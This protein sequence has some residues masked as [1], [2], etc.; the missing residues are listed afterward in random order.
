MEE[1]KELYL[2][3]ECMNLDHISHLV[4]FPLTEEEKKDGEKNKIYFRVKFI[5]YFDQIIPPIRYFYS[6]SDWREYFYYNCFK[7]VGIGLKNIFHRYFFREKG[8]IDFTNFQNKDLS[9]LDIFL[10]QLTDKIDT[11]I[12]HQ[13]IQRLLNERWSI[14][15]SIE[16]LFEDQELPYQLEWNPQFLQCQNIWRRIKNS[17][18]YIFGT[19]C[20]E[21]EFEITEKEASKLRGMIKWIQKTN[22]KNNKE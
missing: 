10:S 19:Y 13:S 17:F 18:A 1:I 2:G 6:L 15:F 4:F 21:Q 11:N 5:S 9:K 8:I 16:K 3:C 14:Y 22:E 12:T 7:K 20:N